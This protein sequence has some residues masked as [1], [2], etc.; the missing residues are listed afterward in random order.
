MNLTGQPATLQ[1]GRMKKELSM[2]MRVLLGM[3]AE[4]VNDQKVS[5]T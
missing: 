5:R 1:A 2:E 3:V 4:N